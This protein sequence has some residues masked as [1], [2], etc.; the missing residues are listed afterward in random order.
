MAPSCVTSGRPRR[1]SIKSAVHKT[2]S[3]RDI[4]A[5]HSVSFLHHHYSAHDMMTSSNGNIFRVTGPLCGQFAGPGEFPAQRPVTRSF[6][7]FFDLRP[8]KR[9]SKQPRGW[10]FETLSW[11]LWRQWNDNPIHCVPAHQWPQ[12]VPALNCSW[13]W[14]I[15]LTFFFTAYPVRNFA[16]ISGK[17]YA[18]R[19]RLIHRIINNTRPL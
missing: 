13:C 18:I 12:H 8:N 5:L 3:A 7:V 14:T 1:Y 9:L 16:V 6:D 2:L 4:N 10:W 19:I 11:S 15:P 17:Y